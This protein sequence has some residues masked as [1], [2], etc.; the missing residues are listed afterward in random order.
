MAGALR[1][2]QLLFPLWAWLRLLLARA[3]HRNQLLYPGL[4]EKVKGPVKELQMLRSVDQNCPAGI[5]EI[6]PLADIDVVQAF[7][8]IEDLGRGYVQAEGA[9][10]ACKEHDIA[11]QMTMPA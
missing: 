1:D 8:K 11:Q 10:Q 5:L 3:E 7:R 2:H 6:L 4:P 9:Q